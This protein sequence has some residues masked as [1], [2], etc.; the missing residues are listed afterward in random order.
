MTLFI[1]RQL[2][3]VAILCL[4]PGITVAKEKKKSEPVR[5]YQCQMISRSDA[6][7][8]AKSRVEGKIVGVQL[9]EKGS[10]SV[11]RVRILVNKKRIKTISIKACR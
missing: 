8:R 11:Y 2:L 3:I 9:T 7:N 4:L 6:I 10:R 5:K 1:N